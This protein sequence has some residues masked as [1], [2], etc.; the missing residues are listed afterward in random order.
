MKGGK[1][2]L[3]KKCLA[4]GFNTFYIYIKNVLDTLFLHQGLM[5][6]L[7]QWPLAHLD[8]GLPVGNQYE[9]LRCGL[10]STEFCMI[11]PQK[12]R[13]EKVLGFSPLSKCI[14]WWRRRY[15]AAQQNQPGYDQGKAPLDQWLLLMAFHNY[16]SRADSTLPQ[17]SRCHEKKSRSVEWTYDI[18]SP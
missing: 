11:C 9:G 12:G 5:G 18:G 14:V 7:E 15:V 4:D 13:H 10:V 17:Q 2:K 1:K 6:F 3:R 16:R 8:S